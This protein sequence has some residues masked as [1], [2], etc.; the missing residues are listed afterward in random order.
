MP[1][2]VAP[3]QTFKVAVT[4]S[5]LSARAPTSLSAEE[6][7]RAVQLAISNSLSAE[8]HANV[9]AESLS[10]EEEERAVQLAI[11]NSMPAETHAESLSGILEASVQQ[12]REELLREAERE[13]ELLRYATIDSTCQHQ[14]R[15]DTPRDRSR[16]EEI[17]RLCSHALQ[18]SAPLSQEEEAERE[19]LVQIA[20]EEVRSQ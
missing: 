15:S 8:T 11:S 12:R 9:F 14:A 18:P 10:A 3:G 7:E 19:A 4:P 6:E 13:S 20:L 16:V 5:S 17:W 2:G 1:R